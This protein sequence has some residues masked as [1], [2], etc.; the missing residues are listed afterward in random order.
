V[1]ALGARGVE[2]GS[3]A[4]ASLRRLRP[5]FA[6]RSASLSE[7]EPGVEAG[8]MAGDSERCSGV[9]MVFVSFPSPSREIMEAS[10]VSEAA[11]DLRRFLRPRFEAAGEDDASAMW[12]SEV[13]PT[14]GVDGV[15]AGGGV[16]A[17]DDVDGVDSGSAS[18]TRLAA[19]PG[20][21]ATA[22]LRAE[23]IGEASA[24]AIRA[25]AGVVGGAD[26]VGG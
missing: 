13:G 25:G 10:G 4:P 7:T 26:G 11:F 17:E 3:A 22:D 2:A 24:V 14:N 8:A 9:D 21:P 18:E 1:I 6:G 15:V 5:L 20:V 16:L 12:E 19:L 23:G